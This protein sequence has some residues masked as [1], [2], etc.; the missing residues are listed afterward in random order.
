MERC[1]QGVRGWRIQRLLQSAEVL[2]GKITCTKTCLELG[3]PALLPLSAIHYE[4]LGK[5]KAAGELVPK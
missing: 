3:L 2:S 4:I 1:C 5:A